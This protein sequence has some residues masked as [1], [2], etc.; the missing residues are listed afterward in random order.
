MGKP[1]TCVSA[2]DLNDKGWSH[3]YGSRYLVNKATI[4]THLI[5]SA[6]DYGPTETVKVM[7]RRHT[8]AYQPALHQR[9]SNE[10]G[11]K[12]CSAAALSELWLV[13]S[14]AAETMIAAFP[15]C[16]EGADVQPVKT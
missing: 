10:H 16:G 9:C 1:D 3:K 5:A 15:T 4:N 2:V 6:I 7:L 13:C 12:P 14:A 11:N 8:T